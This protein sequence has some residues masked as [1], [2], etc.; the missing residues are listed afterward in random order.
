MQAGVVEFGD[1]S[2]EAARIT[3]D[4]VDREEHVEA[5]ERRVFEPL[6]M[7]RP[8]VLLKLHGEAQPLAGVLLRRR[9]I[10]AAPVVGQRAGVDVA[11]QHHLAEDVEERRFH[12]R[13]APPRA[14]DGAFQ[15]GAVFGDPA[16]LVHVG[17][18]D[19]EAGD[20]L[21]DDLAQAVAREVARLAAALGNAVEHVRE[22]G[23]LARH[24]RLD[25]QPLARV[26]HVIER[27]EASGELGVGPAQLARLAGVDVEAVEIVEV[28]VAG[29]PV[30]RRPAR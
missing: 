25:D 30:D 10:A 26:E 11:R 27:L 8:G 24:C 19:R 29:R 13:V 1:G 21:G 14:G 4:F 22:H 12:G 23:E 20:D 28:V 16:V 17:A 2:A 6:R 3:A 7:D 18:V 9:R 15:D 5:V